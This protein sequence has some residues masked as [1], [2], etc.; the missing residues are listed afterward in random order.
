MV[1]K[2]RKHSTDNDKKKTKKSKSVKTDMTTQEAIEKFDESSEEN[3]VTTVNDLIDLTEDNDNKTEDHDKS[4][5][6]EN[7]D[8]D[9]DSDYVFSPNI[10]RTASIPVVISSGD[11]PETAIN[12]LLETMSNIKETMNHVLENNY[13]LSAEIKCLKEE[14]IALGKKMN[15]QEKLTKVAI[16]QVI[17]LKRSNKKLLKKNKNSTTVST[18]NFDEVLAP[19]IKERDSLR[20]EVCALKLGRETILESDQTAGASESQSSYS[21]TL[22]RETLEDKKIRV[23]P[24]CRQLFFRRRDEYKREFRNREKAKIYEKYA[25]IKYLPRKFRPKFSRTSEEFK[26]KEEAA[27]KSLDANRQCCI[28]DADQAFWNY[29]A[30]DEEALAMIQE[31]AADDNEA[32]FLQQLWKK[33]AADA[34]PKGKALCQKELNFLNNLPYTD[35]YRGFLGLPNNSNHRSGSS[36]TT[37]VSSGSS[38]L[39]HGNSYRNQSSYHNGGS[40]EDSYTNNNG[41]RKVARRGNRW[42]NPAPKNTNQQYTSTQNVTTDSNGVWKSYGDSDYR[43]GLQQNQSSWTEDNTQQQNFY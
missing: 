41:W 22:S 17:K 13:A 31:S 33:E 4:L 32:Y 8:D 26:V 23:I 2:K 37:N 3:S 24:R 19:I 15:T 35:H 16:T 38:R 7:H 40:I 12:E 25:E 34:E 5:V 6:S 18:E 43:W 36:N 30:A 10:P 27:F 21:R 29:S 14:N 1:V 42:K 11:I 28:M 9:V 39:N 20:D